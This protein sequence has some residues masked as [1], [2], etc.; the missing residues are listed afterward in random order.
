MRHNLDETGESHFLIPTEIKEGLVAR[1]WVILRAEVM[2]W[3][4]EL[5]VT[6]E[7]THVSD[8]AAPEWGIDPVPAE[9]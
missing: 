9:S 4:Q 5:H 8:M 1:G 6:D 3:A 2:G 7:G